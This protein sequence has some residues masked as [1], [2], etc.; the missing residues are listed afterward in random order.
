MKPENLQSVHENFK[1]FLNY[2]RIAVGGVSRN[3]DKYGN[4]VFRKLLKYGY[5]VFPVNKNTDEIEGHKCY[6]SI[7]DLPQNIDA[8]VLVTPPEQS[9]ELI[10]QANGLGIKNFWL[11]EGAENQEIIDFGKANDLN[12]ITG[13]CIMVQLKR[14]KEPDRNHQLNG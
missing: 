1:A 3:R 12:I 2:K 6:R 8:L 7:D 5:Q 10:R 11:Q 14:M 9:L 13:Y 4:I